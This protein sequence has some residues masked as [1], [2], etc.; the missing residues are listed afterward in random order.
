MDGIELPQD[1][2][3]S[4][5]IRVVIP[6]EVEYD[7]KK[8]QKVTANLMRLLGCTACTSGFDIRYVRALDFVVNPETLDVGELL[9]PT[10]R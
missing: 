2:V 1:P 6:R 5:T 7:L 9:Q 4:R 8:M 3:P 10:W